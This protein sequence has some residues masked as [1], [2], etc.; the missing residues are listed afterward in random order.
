M[1]CL[2]LENKESLSLSFFKF[3]SSRGNCGKNHSRKITHLGICFTEVKLGFTANAQI[4]G[5]RRREEVLNSKFHRQL[6]RVSRRVSFL[7]PLPSFKP[8]FKSEQKELWWLLLFS[9]SLSRAHKVA[10]SQT[11]LSNWA[12]TQDCSPPRFSVYGISQAKILGEKK[13]VAISYSRRSYQSRDQAHIFCIGR[14]F[15]YW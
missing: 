12:H 1:Q 11:Q 5:R 13:W 6:S 15:L 4:R 3:R 14:Q 8:V 9:Q 2:R 10:K 7:N